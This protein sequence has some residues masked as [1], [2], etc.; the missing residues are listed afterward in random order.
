MAVPKTRST[1][2]RGSPRTPALAAVAL[3]ALAAPLCAHDFGSS[4]PL[5]RRRR[6]RR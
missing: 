5:S 3:M 6:E 4:R 1:L 2:R